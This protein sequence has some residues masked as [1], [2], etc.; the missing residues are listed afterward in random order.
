[1]AQEKLAFR[2]KNVFG[3]CNICVQYKEIIKKVSASKDSV[4]FWCQHYSRHLMS[5]K[6]DRHVYYHEREQSR[7]T[8]LG[9]VLGSSSTATLIIDAID[10]A[11]FTLPRHMPAAKLLKDILRP[12]LHVVGVIMHGFFKVGFLID[13]TMAKDS[14]MFIEIVV[15]CIGML[16]KR[17]AELGVRVP[18]RLMIVA[19]NASDNKNQI[20]IF[21]V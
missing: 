20:R 19:D 21:V 14:N 10:Q 11:K 1:M 8:S 4:Q 18:R 15:R 16:V 17:C 12:K 6:E 5:Q 7:L 3:K 2:Q 13:P 9:R